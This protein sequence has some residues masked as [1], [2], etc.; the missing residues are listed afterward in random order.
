MTFW[1]TIMRD[2]LRLWLKALAVCAIATIAVVALSLP[3]PHFTFVVI[4]VFLVAPFALAVMGIGSLWN[5]RLAVKTACTAVPIAFVL[6]G[7]AGWARV[8]TAWTASLW[9]TI[10]AS[11]NA[12]KYGATFEHTAERVLMWFIVGGALGASIA[13]LGSVWAIARVSGRAA[14]LLR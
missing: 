14:S 2:S 11:M 3:V 12:A 4:S 7:L 9:I 13:A 8:P 10:D 1:R 5:V 6:G